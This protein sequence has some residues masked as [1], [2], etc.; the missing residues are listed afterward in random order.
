[1]TDDDRKLL[2]FNSQKENISTILIHGAWFSQSKETFAKSV[3]W[4]INN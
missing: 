4:K 2:A 1:M 3:N